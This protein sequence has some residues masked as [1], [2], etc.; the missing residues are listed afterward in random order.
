MYGVRSVNW[1]EAFSVSLLR[2]DGTPFLVVEDD[3]G[4]QHVAAPPGAVRTGAL[5][6]RTRCPERLCFV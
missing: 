3:D 4:V 1:K 5:T 6:R 2:S